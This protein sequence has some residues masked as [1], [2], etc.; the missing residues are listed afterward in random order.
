MDIDLLVI[1]GIFAA[2]GCYII[3]KLRILKKQD[4]E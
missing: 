2:I 3:S 1:L 4:D